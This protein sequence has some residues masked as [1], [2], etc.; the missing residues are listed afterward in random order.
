MGIILSTPH[1]RVGL[2]GIV[3]THYSRRAPQSFPTTKR[4]IKQA[5]FTLMDEAEAFVS[6]L[7]T[8]ELP[9]RSVA[10]LADLSDGAPLFDVLSIMSGMDL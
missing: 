9:T 7:A 5:F 8:Y 1:S 3:W 2:F 10:T 4:C 6:W